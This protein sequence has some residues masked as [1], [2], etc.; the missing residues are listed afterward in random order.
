[1]SLKI[2]TLLCTCLVALPAFAGDPK[3]PTAIQPASPLTPG[4]ELYVT[5]PM[6]GAGLS[7]N[8]GIAGYE[9]IPVDVPFKSILENLDM[10]AALTLEARHRRWG[11][12]LD[13][14]Y[15]K[16]SASGET[17]GRLL[18][19]IDVQVEQVLAEATV[20]Y[21]LLEGDR[22]YLDLLAGARYMYLGSELNFHLDSAGVRD[23]SNDLSDAI[24]DRAASAIQRQV[25]AAV[26]RAQAR[27]DALNLDERA[28][29]LRAELRSDLRTAA[30]QK[31]LE[32]NAV[33]D[34]IRAIAGLTPAERALVQQKI[35]GR[36]DIIAAN[37]ALAEAVIQERVATAV[38]AARRKAQQ[39]VARAKKQLAG[40]IEN[41]IRDVLPEEVSGSK[42][43]VDPF[44]GFRA[45][46]NVTD[47]LYIA[48]RGDVG[49]FG[50]GSDLSWNA[51]GA[52]GYQWNNRFSTEMGYRCLSVDYSEDGFVYDT[53]TSGV[54]LGLTFKL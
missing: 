36:K 29:S 32:A 46:Y 25:S 7:G 9:P 12:I 13:G 31:A 21:R 53:E 42:S 23:L 44:V 22:G 11:F 34:I 30:I 6:W 51:V 54:F 28:A 14:M 40:A 5:L 39:A 10:T 35:Q 1:M 24:V 17:P 27:L 52:I 43:W 15:L 18:T 16:M 47:K 38:A 37:K 2:S 3:A 26:A 48:G 19:S 45:R 41:A 49:G 50:V 8:V 33:R 4:W 20:A